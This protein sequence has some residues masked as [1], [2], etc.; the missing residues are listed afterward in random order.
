MKHFQGF[1]V[2]ALGAL[3]ALVAGGC[4]AVPPGAYPFQTAPVTAEGAFYLDPAD[5]TY[6]LLVNDYTYY[7]LYDLPMTENLLYNKGYDRVRGKQEADFAVQLTFSAGTYDNP[8]A[9]AGHALGGALLGAATG[10]IIGGA[11]RN[12]GAGAAI[13]AASGGALGLLAPANAT[14]LTIQL[15]FTSMRENVN[16]RR[17][18]TLDLTPLPPHEVRQAVDYEVTRLLQPLP[19]R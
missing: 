7:G 10:A 9:R 11:A 12:P 8:Q 16:A 3:L 1:V 6:V 2:M 19:P 4:A 17:I 5:R 18:V 14:L 15:D 13:G